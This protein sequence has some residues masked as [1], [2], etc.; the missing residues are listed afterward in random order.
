MSEEA[1]PIVRYGS[2]MWRHRW[3]ILAVCA[4]T[5]LVTLLV[6]LRLP[7]IYQSTATL[8][9]PK[10]G[11]ANLVGGLLGSSLLLQQ[12]QGLAASTGL[13]VPSLT[14]NRDVLLA[15]LRSR[16]LGEAVVDKFGLQERYRD[17]YRED[18]LK[19][20]AA[21]TSVSVSKEGVISVRV[22]DTD[23]QAAAQMANYY[24]QQ[25]DQL[26]SRYGS[27][28]AGHQAKFLTEQLA[29]ATVELAETEQKLRRF[30]ERNRAI[31]LTEQTKG[32]IE[33]AARLKGEIVAAEVQLKVLRSFA[34]DNNVE[35]VALRH[36]IEE[37]NRQ[38]ALF[39]DGVAQRDFS[40][41]FARVPE[42][43][44]DLA[45]L[46]REVKVHE[47]V[48]ML[49]TQNLE[50]ARIN[51]ARDMPVVQVLDTAIPAERPAK[52]SLKLNLAL[53]GLASLLASMLLAM[54][55]DPLGGP[56]RLA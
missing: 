40:V 28:E 13:S 39:G 29:R 43:T 31:I 34:T 52:P 50:Q 37:M 25:L 26:V 17:R 30:Q 6:T 12:A 5:V 2:I 11:G 54:F 48:V 3:M 4:V 16:T 22:E 23:P 32:A 14:P 55:L 10:E 45:R 47:V 15:V 56:T 42:L 41:P 27:G 35:V 8:M 44:V 33:A 7:K 46:T 18:A 1:A 38:L 20:L 49:L 53:A 36:R 21:A 9:A 24:V 51:E 19:H